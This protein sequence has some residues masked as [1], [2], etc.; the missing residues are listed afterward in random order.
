M[1][2]M[3]TPG[4][5]PGCMLGIVLAAVLIAMAQAGGADLFGTFVQIVQHYAGG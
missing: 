1:R 5:N 4:F 2:H 3:P